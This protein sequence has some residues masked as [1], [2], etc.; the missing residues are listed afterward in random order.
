MPKCRAVHNS[1]NSKYCIG[2][3]YI[4]VDYAVHISV[5]CA[6]YISVDCTAHIS[7]DCAVYISVDCAQQIGTVC[8]QFP[9]KVW[10]WG[11]CVRGTSQHLLCLHF[12]AIV[13]VLCLHFCAIVAML[14]LH[15]CAI[16]AVLYL[17]FSAIIVAVLCLHFCA[18]V[19]VF[20]CSSF[21]QTITFIWK[22]LSSLAVTRV[23]WQYLF[24]LL[25]IDTCFFTRS[26]NFQEYLS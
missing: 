22:Y 6:V 5:D 26:K 2:A 8:A 23:Y 20:C 12:S 21:L 15:F 16:V 24:I 9:G 25:S 18:I 17:H 19:A 3:L 4:S 10:L 11:T 7:V 13:A 1:V 14:C